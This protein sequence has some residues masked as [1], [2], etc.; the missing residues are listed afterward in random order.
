MK[1]IFIS[2]YGTCLGTLSAHILI[3]S[4]PSMR[5][6]LQLAH[7]RSEEALSPWAQLHI[8]WDF[9]AV[10]NKWMFICDDFYSRGLGSTSKNLK[11]PAGGPCKKGTQV[12]VMQFYCRDGLQQHFH[13]HEAF[14]GNTLKVDVDQRLVHYLPAASP[15]EPMLRLSMNSWINILH[16]LY[17]VVGGRPDV[18]LLQVDTLTHEVH[19]HC[20][21][22]YLRTHTSCPALTVS[23]E[24][25]T[26]PQIEEVDTTVPSLSSSPC[27]LQPG[28]ASQ[29]QQTATF[30]V[31]TPLAPP[32]LLQQPPTTR[33][34]FPPTSTSAFIQRPII[35]SQ[36]T[37]NGIVTPQTT[38]E[39]STDVPSL[40]TSSPA[41]HLEP[42]PCTPPSDGEQE[43]AE[44]NPE[45]ILEITLNK[46]AEKPQ[47]KPAAH[48]QP[49]LEKRRRTATDHTSKSKKTQ[50]P[51]KRG[52]KG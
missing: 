50:T 22:R 8:W 3:G 28:N 17:S 1:L 36:D 49:P 10:N 6:C 15:I 25:Q 45:G 9:R 47:E 35:A 12:A 5:K 42:S 4:A 21:G 23:K 16:C 2:N 39:Q 27:T 44:D 37:L 7:C 43:R 33:E 40:E 18:H 29:I 41:L 48:T 26:G 19:L 14:K 24:I 34:T 31:L 30:T 11:I 51:T 32:V 13:I 52:K 20:W 38:D 46:T